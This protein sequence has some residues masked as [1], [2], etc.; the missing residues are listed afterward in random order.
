MLLNEK[1]NAIDMGVRSESCKYRSIINR[2]IAHITRKTN[3]VDKKEKFYVSKEVCVY[4]P[5]TQRKVMIFF[6]KFFVVVCATIN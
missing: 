3:D 4:L 1:S 6:L 2:Y 5:G